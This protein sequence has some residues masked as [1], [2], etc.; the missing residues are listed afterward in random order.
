MR[1][2]ELLESCLQALSNGQE[3]P[4]DIARYLAHH[5]DK[6]AEVE[7]L[8]FMAQRASQLPA[9]ELAA[10]RRE[11]MQERLAARMGVDAA[12]LAPRPA[13]QEAHHE[14]E[15]PPLMGTR[16]RRWWLLGAGRTSLLRLR[17]LNA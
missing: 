2:D 1:T 4:P 14:H 6:R 15:G 16:K 13:D 12:T 11:R 7:E 9:A 10:A 5:P 17:Y 8:I 3:I